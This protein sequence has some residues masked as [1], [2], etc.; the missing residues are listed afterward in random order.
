[1]KT[2]LVL[3]T[4]FFP[5]L[6]NSVEGQQPLIGSI[7]G[8]VRNQQ[9]AFIQYATITL[10]NID[11]IE[12]END[13]QWNMTDRR[14]LYQFVFVPPGRYSIMVETNGYLNCTIPLVS[15]YPGQEVIVPEIKMSPV[16]KTYPKKSLLPMR[17]CN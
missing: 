14:G 6:A 1:M 7:Q 12:P 13:R 11:N 10:T 2:C 17:N 5:C 15:V 4:A 16:R 3:F 9:R 8:T